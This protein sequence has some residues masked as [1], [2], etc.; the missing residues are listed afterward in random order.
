M[1]EPLVCTDAAMASSPT[2]ASAASRI[3]TRLSRRTGILP[4]LTK[5]PSSSRSDWLRSTRYR[6]FTSKALPGGRAWDKSTMNQL[7][8][9]KTP[10]AEATRFTAK[11]GQ[12]LAF[13]WAYSQI[14]CRAPAEADFERYFKVTQA[15]LQPIRKRRQEFAL[16]PDA[17][18]RLVER[19]TTDACDVAART[20]ADVR[21]TFGITRIDPA[22]HV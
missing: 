6:T 20:L 22:R 7:F 5:V 4:P 8:D 10:A 1:V 16:D 13:I 9:Q 19:G 3:C 2:P 14:N 11:Q 18:M 15:V 17:V 12:C 21:A